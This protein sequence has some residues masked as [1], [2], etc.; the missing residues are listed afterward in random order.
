M[1][2][3]GLL[4]DTR[5]DTNKFLVA[6]T[7]NFKKRNYINKEGLSPIYLYVTSGN[8]RKRIHL[9]LYVNPKTWN[10]KTSRLDGSDQIV[11]DQNLILDNIQSKVTKIK[12]TYRLSSKMLTI[13]S[14]FDEFNNEMPR[15]NFIT[16]YKRMLEERKNTISTGTYTKEHSIYKKLKNYNEEILFCDID[17]MFFVKFRNYL[18]GLKNN[19]ATRN[20]NIKIIKK[21]LRFATKIGVK[22]PIDLS[23]IVAGSTKGNRTF[24]NGNEIERCYKY[25]NSDFIAESNRLVM[26]YFL[27]A[28]FT[29][30]RISD[31]NAIKRKDLTDHTYTFVHI[32]TGRQQSI[33]LNKKAIYILNNCPNLFIATL[34]PQHINGTIKTIMLQLGIQKKVTFHTARHS[35]GTNYILLGG[36][37]VT[38][39]QLMNHAAITETMIYVHMAELEKNSE[40]DLLDQLF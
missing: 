9:D 16:F 14:F 28:C 18:G 38:L 8:K 5:I 36:N 34:S 31:I 23:D 19:K 37:I 1:I 13:N 35:F 3:T 25:F 4:F 10:P 20:S 22:L 12:T 6:M 26:G 40:A 7:I 33:T 11:H 24:L 15:A 32:K 21:Y 27:F 39:Q 30:L 17:A 29:G 2:A